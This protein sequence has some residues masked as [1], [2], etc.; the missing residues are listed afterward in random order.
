MNV[1]FTLPMGCNIIK[2]QLEFNTKLDE[3]FARL[4]NI[5]HHSSARHC[6]TEG[7]KI[8]VSKET[9]L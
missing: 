9:T 8:F 3:C 6:K 1:I 2:M 7:R 5:W 4:K